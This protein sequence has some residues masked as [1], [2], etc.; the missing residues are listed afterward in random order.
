MKKI[1][2]FMIFFSTGAYHEAISII[3]LHN[4]FLLCFEVLHKKTTASIVHRGI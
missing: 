4:N 2:F 1:F 3:L